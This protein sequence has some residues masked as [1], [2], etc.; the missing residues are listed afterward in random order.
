MGAELFICS[1]GRLERALRASSHQDALQWFR[2][3]MAMTVHA[4]SVAGDKTVRIKGPVRS[5]HDGTLYEFD[6]ETG[7][8]LRTIDLRPKRRR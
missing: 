2:S 7:E 3:D 1:C 4:E 5:R 6:R 8:V